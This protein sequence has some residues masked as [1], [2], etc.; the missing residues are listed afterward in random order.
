VS[1][2]RV[3][4]LERLRAHFESLAG[5][6]RVAAERLLREH[7][8]WD[9]LWRVETPASGYDAAGAPFARGLGVFG[10]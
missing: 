9:P 8:A 3:W 4:C 10:P 2:Y 6:A 1:R 7:G 5:D